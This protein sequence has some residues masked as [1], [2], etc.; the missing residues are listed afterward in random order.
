MIELLKMSIFKLNFFQKRDKILKILKQRNLG[1]R[2]YFPNSFENALSFFGVDYTVQGNV[3]YISSF[4]PR[5]AFEIYFREHVPIGSYE[6]Y[7][8]RAKNLTD[9]N[10]CKFEIVK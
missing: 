1:Y 8:N 9:K 5:V 10:K 2:V 7:V 6:Y 3:F 4:N